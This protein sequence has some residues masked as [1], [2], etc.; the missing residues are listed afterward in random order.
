M[1]ANGSTAL[2]VNLTR[3]LLSRSKDSEFALLMASISLACK[4]ISSAVRKA[5]ISGLYG[6]DGS[7]NATGD[8]VKKLDVLSNDNFISALRS[9]RQACVLV[10]EEEA[11]PVVIEEANR[12]AYCV[13]FDPLDGSSNIDC[14]VSVGSIFGIYKKTDGAGGGVGTFGVQIAKQY[15]TEVTGVDTGEKLKMMAELGFDHIIDYKQ[16]DFTRNGIHYDLILDANKNVTIQLNETPKDLD[17]QINDLMQGIDTT[18]VGAAP[19]EEHM[20]D[21]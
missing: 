3:Y 7:V 19:A 10:S 12:G 6:L 14:N 15:D 20:E 18:A 16:Q 11:D 9:S 1:A 2:D 5:G 8:D 21:L 4:V 17:Q 13:V